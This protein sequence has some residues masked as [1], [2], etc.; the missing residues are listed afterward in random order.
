MVLVGLTN[1]A[2]QTELA[3]HPRLVALM[4]IIKV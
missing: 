4:G 2:V 1:D 3:A